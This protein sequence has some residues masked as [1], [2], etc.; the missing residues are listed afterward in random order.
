MFYIMFRQCIEKGSYCMCDAAL[1]FA[2]IFVEVLRN[3]HGITIVI[4][5]FDNTPPIIITLM[6]WL[7]EADRVLLFDWLPY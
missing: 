6:D 3:L 5:A 4:L 7:R 2:E 1:P